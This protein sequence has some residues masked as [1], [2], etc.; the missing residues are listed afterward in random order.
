MERQVNLNSIL[1]TLT[2]ALIATAWARVEMAM[3]E[4]PTMQIRIS[5][6]EAEIM[7]MKDRQRKLEDGFDLVR[8]GKKRTELFPS[9]IGRVVIK[10]RGPGGREL[11]G[12]MPAL[13]RPDKQGTDQP[14]PPSPPE[15]APP[16]PADRGRI[17][18]VK[19][20]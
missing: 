3:R 5:V 16:Q 20:G 6:H 7:N 13:P 1:I 9:D 10:G 12:E 2:M 17:W 11:R 14:A 19:A 18:D 15:T 8:G 4:I